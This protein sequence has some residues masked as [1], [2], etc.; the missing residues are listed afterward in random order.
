MKTGEQ[1]NS[2]RLG[3]QLLQWL[4]PECPRPISPVWRYGLAVLIGVAITTLR[5]ALVPWLGV[6]APYNFVIFGVVI[7]TALLGTGPG[8]VAAILSVFETE[9]FIIGSLPNA[10]EGATLVRVGL[11]LAICA[12]IVGLFHVL[13]A[14]HA[15]SVETQARL[16]ALGAA[17]FEGI[18]ESEGG[19]IVQCNEAFARMMGRPVAQLNGVA[20]A[21]LIP[22]EDRERVL[23]NIEAN[24]ESAIEHAML[25]P[26]GTRLIVEARGRPLLPG[27]NRRQTVLRDITERKQAEAALRDNERKFRALFDNSRDAILVY[28]MAGHF[29]DANPEACQRLGYSRE[30]LL[31]MGPRDIDSPEAAARV[32]ER[33]QEIFEHGHALFETEHQRRDGSRVHVESNSTL[34]DFGGKKLVFSTFRDITARKRAEK[35]LRESESTL[36]SFYQSAPQMMGVVELPADNSDIIHMHSN[37]A[38]NKFFGHPEGNTA[39][40]SALAMGVPEEAV[41][42]WIEQYRLAEREGK[43]VQF[44][45]WHPRQNGA[46]WLSAVVAMIGPADSGRTRFSFVV[47]DATARKRAEVALQESEEQFRTIF[48]VSSVGKA[49]ADPATGRLLKV[50][51]AYCQITG[52]TEA[53]LLT[54]T[55]VDLSPPEDREKAWAI[56]SRLCSGQAAAYEVEKRYVRKDGRL[57]WVRVYGNLIRDEAGRPLRAVAVIEDITDRRAFQAEL[58]RQVAERTEKLQEMVGELEHFSYSITHDLKAPLRAMKGFAEM[59]SMLCADCASEDAK[60]ALA[61]IS[62]SAERMEALI[63]DA[64]NY[65]R[66]LRQEL[67][68]TDVDTG[69][70]LQGMLESYPELQ[71]SKAHIQVEGKLPVVLGNEAALTQC[72]SNLLGN[73]VKFVK[74]GDKP[75]VRVWAE[76]RDG[77]ARIWVEDNGIGISKEMLPR[78]FDMFSR[79]SKDYEGTGIGLALVRKVMQRMGG[80]TGV[81]SE[82]GHGSK[83]WIELELGESRPEPPTQEVASVEPKP[84]TV[85]YVEDEE[86][87][88]TFMKLAFAGKGLES[89][90]QVVPDGRTAIEYLSGEGEY[91]DRK[92]HP[93]PLVVL[94]DL[95]LPQVSGF[96]VLKWI[97]SH[98]DFAWLPVVVFSSSTRKDDQ[99]KALELGA[100]EFVS[101]PTSGLKFSEV[102]ERLQENWVGA[103]A[104][105]A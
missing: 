99:V 56:F 76:E 82:E 18:V 11:S 52:Y 10:F 54:H 102:V 93:L 51:P 55:L 50:N 75:Q 5:R 95:N 96:E 61:R 103:T 57:I 98:P 2:K 26:D 81:E 59:A 97:R 20:F 35:A 73:A 72:F 21:E 3:D 70:L 80:R 46:V 28:D 49:Q 85:L 38:T 62:T 89:A 8:L 60:E 42:R 79:G 44:E 74:P 67:P 71:P 31:R 27:S 87:D 41:R 47:S 86:C 40:K 23:A 58:E 63:T 39:G 78:V 69:A 101:K 12:F 25:R 30:E 104:Q 94:L 36:R 43:P 32:P 37:P 1:I 17:S 19:R 13:R 77:W 9:I 64:L 92:E 66:S 34:V 68:L 90:L 4:A 48:N 24:R 15:R 29:A 16:A 100:N 88:A 84:G 105:P 14:A 33:L 83:F 91:A 7:A 65:S 22:P 45:Y 53:E 6:T